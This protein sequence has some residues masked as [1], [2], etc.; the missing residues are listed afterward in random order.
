MMNRALYLFFLG[1]IFSMV[2]PGC[3]DPRSSASF[4]PVTGK[5]SS[6]WVQ[7]HG[8][9]FLSDALICYECHGDALDG[10]I[11][12]LGCFSSERDG[13]ACHGSGAFHGPG[14]GDP[15]LHGPDAKAI[16][17]R[18]KGFQEC[19]VCHGDD[20]SGGIMRVSCYTSSCHDL[21]VPHSPAPWNSVSG[22][23]MHMDTNWQNTDVCAICHLGE[24]STPAPAG[25]PVN[26][27]NNTL[28]HGNVSHDEGWETDH[29]LTARSD[30]TSC[31][32]DS[33]H[34]TDYRG[35]AVGV[36]CYDCHL[37]GPNDS[38]YIMHPNLWMDPEDTHD[39]YLESR[40]GNATSCSPSWP[41]IA[42]YCHGDGLPDNDTLLTAPP[43]NSWS[44]GPTCYD[45][46]DREW[47]SP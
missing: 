9:R 20:F 25:T 6:S 26:C 18:Y 24:T 7:E 38:D 22:G 17:E 46:H 29:A 40:G 47:S 14:W 19:R 30:N 28:C 27:F 33:C 16:P 12:E 31:A 41:G 23:Y 42:Q 32:A 2:L 13:V 10:G 15:D 21:G 4:D 5:H 39:N 11:S 8:S 44:K 1:I 43:N 34:G 36:G 35:G 37:G 45:C 3:G